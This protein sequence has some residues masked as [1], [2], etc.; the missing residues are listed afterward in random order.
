MPFGWKK[1]LKTTQHGTS[2]SKEST[3]QRIARPAKVDSFSFGA[4]TEDVCCEFA[5]RKL[6]RSSTCVGFEHL[7]EVLKPE[8]TSLEDLTKLGRNR[9]GR[10]A[11]PDEAKKPVLLGRVPKVRAQSRQQSFDM[12]W[13]RPNSKRES[14]FVPK[15]RSIAGAGVLPLPVPSVEEPTP[16]FEGFDAMLFQAKSSSYVAEHELEKLLKRK[17]DMAASELDK[18]GLL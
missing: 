4:K 3:F 14:N 15:R 11:V 10:C 9:L 6:A 5:S 12:I 13:P 8:Y 16:G 7:P 17:K 2:I 1:A 18:L